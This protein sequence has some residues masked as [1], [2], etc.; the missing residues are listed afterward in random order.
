MS[1]YIFY[2]AK[3]REDLEEIY[4]YIAFNLQ[5]P[6]TAG[7]PCWR[8]NHGGAVD[9]ASCLLRIFLCFMPSMKKRKT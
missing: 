3:A 8:M 5:E 6:M 4:E 1:Y 7:T 2:T 9:F